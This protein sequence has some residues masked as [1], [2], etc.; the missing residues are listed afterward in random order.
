[1]KN[2]L[3]TENLDQLSIIERTALG[4][5]FKLGNLF[6][7]KNE[8]FYNYCILSNEELKKCS[9]LDI[10][11]NEFSMITRS[12]FKKKIKAFSLGLDESFS[13]LIDF[14]NDNIY[15]NKY[16]N[17]YF[18]YHLDEIDEN[19]EILQFSLIIR[20]ITKKMVLNNWNI[21]ERD[22]NN[23]FDKANAT[24][25]ITDISYG[26][27]FHINFYLDRTFFKCNKKLKFKF[28][29]KEKIEKF[30]NKYFSNY[31]ISCYEK[32][33][34]SNLWQDG[35]KNF[36]YINKFNEEVS[37]D[38]I[39]DNSTEYIKNNYYDAIR[40]KI[41]GD[42]VPLEFCNY[43]SLS[44][45]EIFLKT[46][47]KNILKDNHEGYGF[48]IK[49]TLS[50]LF[51][52]KRTEFSS[53]NLNEVF[54]SQTNKKIKNFLKIKNKES[55]IMLFSNILD[56]EIVLKE[57]FSDIKLLNEIFKIEVKNIQ[58]LLKDISIFKENLYLIIYEYAYWRKW[59]LNGLFLSNNIEDKYLNIKENEINNF[60][61][62]EDFKKIENEYISLKKE[63]KEILE[64][65]DNKKKFF[66]KFDKIDYTILQNKFDY[67]N[68]FLDK[69][70]TK[71]FSILFFINLEI[72]NAF[73]DYDFLEN[74]IFDLFIGIFDKYKAI[75]TEKGWNL[76]ALQNP[77]G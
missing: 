12:N 58:K 3:D 69:E 51:N 77:T 17:N 53:E 76:N 64:K 24:H 21:T 75:M 5:Y 65:L 4:R 8:K 20:I 33:P 57:S 37:R 18:N 71:S 55:L 25:F 50:S 68:V 44:N 39:D 36:I 47:I 41:L 13:I 23:I 38:L 49:Y 32:E 14:E 42:G 6:N 74:N 43:N 7:I 56:L 31:N 46:G 62:D 9:S 30:F 22:F 15:P 59:Y 70:K 73:D 27:Y 35:K 16:L 2:T 11:K 34:D 72:F 60:N 26:L 52:I 48:P 66:C 28:F 67:K 63:S 10:K 45:L 61:K 19:F 29:L 40:V 54:N 1:M